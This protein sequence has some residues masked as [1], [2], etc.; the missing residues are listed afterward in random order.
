MKIKDDNIVDIVENIYHTRYELYF[1]LFDKAI[2]Y[3][4]ANKGNISFQDFLSIAKTIGEIDTIHKY[5]PGLSLSEL[6]VTPFCVYN[7]GKY[8]VIYNIKNP[9]RTLSNFSSEIDNNIINNIYYND[10]FIKFDYPYEYIGCFVSVQGGYLYLSFIY[11]EK[12]KWA[13]E[14]VYFKAN[15][16][17]VSKSIDNTLFQ[18]H[19]ATYMAVTQTVLEKIKICSQKTIQLISAINTGYKNNQKFTIDQ[20]KIKNV[21]SQSIYTDKIHIKKGQVLW[22]EKKSSISSEKFYDYKKSIKSTPKC[23]H[24]RRAGIRNKKIYDSYGNIIGYKQIKYKSSIIHK[25]QYVDIIPKEI[26]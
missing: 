17:N 10:F 25:E 4:N 8:R 20:V 22:I 1:K 26:K 5:S 3:E 14:P 2:E 18:N 23:P 24:T 21:P 7:W 12:N 15:I 13:S 6:I 11:Q 19:D 16:S 9:D